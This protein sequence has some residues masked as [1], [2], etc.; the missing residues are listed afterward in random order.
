MMIWTVQAC[1]WKVIYKVLKC[2]KLKV[3]DHFK[4][5]WEFTLLVTNFIDY[6]A[7][8]VEATPKKIMDSPIREQTEVYSL[9][10]NAEKLTVV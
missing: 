5:F 7:P 10:I 1:S 6:E 9:I 8:I 3:D 2:D 4:N